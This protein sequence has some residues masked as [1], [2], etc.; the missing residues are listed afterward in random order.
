MLLQTIDVTIEEVPPVGLVLSE[1]FLNAV[2]GDDGFEWV[3]IY[4]GTGG[5]VDLSDYTIGH[6]NGGDVDAG[7]AAF[8]YT[9]SGVLEDEA[10]VVVGGPTSS[11]SNGNPTFFLT[12]DFDPDI[13]NSGSG[14]KAHGVVLFLETDSAI[15]AATIPSDLVLY[16]ANN[17]RQYMD[18]SGEP[19]AA[20]N[21]EAPQEGKSIQRTANGWVVNPNPTPGTCVV[22]GE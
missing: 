5:Q 4:N 6:T 16:G 12:Q 7:Y 19:A 10:C 21:V 15:G 3:E 22:L 8:Q 13:Q 18:L 2:Q 14:E 1:I 17:D 11:A 9:L 20:P